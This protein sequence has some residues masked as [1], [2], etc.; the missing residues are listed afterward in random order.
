MLGMTT[1]CPG[2]VPLPRWVWLPSVPEEYPYHARYAYPVPQRSTPTM[3]G[4]VTQCPRG[5]PLLC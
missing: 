1:K 5:V 4:M 2:G 3:L